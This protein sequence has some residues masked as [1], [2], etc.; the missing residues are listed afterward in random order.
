MTDLPECV[1]DGYPLYH[2]MYLEIDVKGVR[3]YIYY[4][5][6]RRGIIIYQ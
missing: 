1:Q 3:V 4:T 5:I 2:V 6:G